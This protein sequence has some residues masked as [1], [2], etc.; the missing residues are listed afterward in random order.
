METALIEVLLNGNV[1]NTIIKRVTASEVTIL[2]QIHGDDAVTN[3]SDIIKTST[4]N[5]E[6][7]ERLRRVYGKSAVEKSFPG[8]MPVLPS[9]FASVGIDVGNERS[10]RKQKSE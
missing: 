10:A 5:P 3:P 6:E 8:S 4:S 9:T 7:V 1:G 2:K